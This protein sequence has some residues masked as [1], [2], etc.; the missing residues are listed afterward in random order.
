MR[1]SDL[2]HTDDSLVTALLSPLS[3]ALGFHTHGLRSAADCL[4]RRLFPGICGAGGRYSDA[5]CTVRSAVAV[6]R[7]D[8]R[9]ARLRFPAS[10]FGLARSATPGTREPGRGWRLLP[11]GRPICRSVHTL[12]PG[13]PRAVVLGLSG[14]GHDASRAD[15]LR[16]AKTKPALR[17]VGGDNPELVAA[18]RY[19]AT[20]L[21]GGLPTSATAR[22]R[23]RTRPVANWWW[24]QFS[25]QL[26]MRANNAANRVPT[27]PALIE[28]SFRRSS[29]ASGYNTMTKRQSRSTTCGVGV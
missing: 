14:V 18:W 27:I 23:P 10:A 8:H 24:P 5:R 9:D 13:A 26:P 20:R 16:E 19:R 1:R 15:A 6:A 2:R 22:R 12:S 3:A 29:R 28:L 17:L 7:R 4:V 21:A 25:G 11:S